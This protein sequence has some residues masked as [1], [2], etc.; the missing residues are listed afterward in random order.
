MASSSD[1]DIARLLREVEALESGGRSKTPPPA[2]PQGKEAVPQQ[3][4]GSR[5][6]LWTLL[7]AVGGGAFGFLVGS[8]LFFLPWVDGMSTS[9]GAALG[10]ALAAFISGPPRWMEK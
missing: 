2:V 9:V 1:D 6:G 4:G 10:A 7:A 5:R 8:L 3:E